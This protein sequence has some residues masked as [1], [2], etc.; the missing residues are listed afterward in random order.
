[1]NAFGNEVRFLNET[2][3]TATEKKFNLD[4]KSVIK[5]TLKYIGLPHFGARLRAFHFSKLLACVPNSARILDAG[6]GIGLNAFLAARYGFKVVGID[7]DS[8][9]ISIAKKMLSGAKYPQVQFKVDDLTR[10]SFS[11]QSFDT[12]ICSEVLEHIENDG[13]AISEIARVLKGNGTLLLSVPG[14]GIVSKINQNHKHHVREGYS[15]EELREKLKKQKLRITKVI[16]IEHT[17]LGLFVRYLNDEIS[18][19]SLFAS[20]L[21]F[22]IFLPLGIFDSFLPEIITPNNWIIVA[23]KH[24]A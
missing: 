21:F 11:S 9:K 5:Q 6:C 8:E 19:R 7:I 10:L 16:K 24:N 23:K 20:V 1:M 15:L 14:K 13:K 12:V 4:N 18:Q 3:K 17:P 22:P 2:I